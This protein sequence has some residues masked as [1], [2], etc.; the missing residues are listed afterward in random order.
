MRSGRAPFESRAERRRGGAL[1]PTERRSPREPQQR[2]R[3]L[4]PARGGRGRS[5]GNRR[6]SLDAARDDLGG[7]RAVRPAGLAE[8]AHAELEAPTGVTDLE[9]VA[10]RA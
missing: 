9:P 10:A 4:P 1:A 7:G 2:E 6:S 8:H 3:S 5:W